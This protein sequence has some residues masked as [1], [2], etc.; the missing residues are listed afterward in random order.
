VITLDRVTK[1]FADGNIAV[2][3]LSLHVDEGELCVFLGPS[4]CGKT[5]T[6]RMINRMIEPSSGHIVVDGEDV[7]AVDPVQLRRRIGYVI[8]QVGLFPHQSV[9]AN[10]A[11]VPKL[12]G[13][14]KA[15]IAHRVDELLE[16]VGLD[17]DQH[18]RRYPNQL[19]GGQQ[20]RVG[21]ARALAADPPVLLMD[22]PFGAL[23]PVTRG[24]LQ[25]ELLQ[26]QAQLRK[27]IVFVT[28]DL[29]EAVK[30]GNRIAIFGEHGRLAQFDT[31]RRL[32]Q[33]PADDY[34]AGF[35][36]ADRGLKL[37][38]TMA[39]SSVALLPMNG[40]VPALE[41]APTMSAR[42]ALS[43]LLL[44]GTD[45]AVVLGTDGNPPLGIVTLDALRAS[46]ANPTDT[47]ATT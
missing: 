8:Q 26:L 9:A 14:D 20:Q 44:A 13:W 22:E 19:S 18:R 43:E 5:T 7:L 38:A 15:R 33:H 39:L 32:L 28:H 30:L 29:D 34:V 3:A 35:L 31:P 37:L 36:G 4:G 1:R 27:T 40:S 46:A 17:P 45:R 24:R 42:D 2:D 47:A 11:T 6:L 25:D 12:L 10:V 16:L 21:V 41:I 23:D